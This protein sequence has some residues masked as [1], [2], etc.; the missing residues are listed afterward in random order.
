MSRCSACPAEIL[1]ATTRAGRAIP[2]NQDPHPQGNVR[3]KDGV[4]EVL[5]PLEAYA[6]RAAKEPLHVAHF[7]TCPGA[8]LLRKPRRPVGV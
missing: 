4:A 1:W 5:G 3:V 7:V 8:D 6:A 2:L